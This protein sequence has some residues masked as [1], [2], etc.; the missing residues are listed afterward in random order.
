MSAQEDIAK[1]SS[2]EEVRHRTRPQG[3]S[4]TFGTLKSTPPSNRD[5]GAIPTGLPR[6][7]A[8]LELRSSGLRPSPLGPGRS[9]VFIPGQSTASTRGV[10][11]GEVTEVMGPR[12]VGKTAFAMGIAAS[13]LQAGQKVVWIDTA[14]PVNP[15]RFKDI[16]QKERNTFTPDTDAPSPPQPKDINPDDPLKNLHHFHPPTLA[17]LLALI[18]HPPK[19]FPPPETGLIVIDSI[20]S[21]F[22]SEYRTKMPPKRKSTKPTAES[23]EERTRWKIIGNLAANLKKLATKLNCA[24]ITINEMA[25]RFRPGQPPVLH[26]TLSGV[27]WDAGVATRLVLYWH[28][29]PAEFRARVDVRMKRVRIAEV[30][31][32]ERVG[33]VAG[34]A[35][36]IVPFVI[37]KTG[38]HEFIPPTPNNSDGN[39]TDTPLPPLSIRT[40]NRPN[41]LMQARSK[42][43]LDHAALSSDILE[44]R[45]R[46]RIDPGAIDVDVEIK[47]EPDDQDYVSGVSKTTPFDPS[48]ALGIKGEGEGDGEE[49]CEWLDEDD[50]GGFVGEEVEEDEDGDGDRDGKGENTTPILTPDVV[51]IDEETVLLLENIPDDE[52]FD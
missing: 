16:L 47:A 30:V 5:R 35:G 42:R 27:T 20:S 44:A 43:K 34:R 18:S 25:S 36:R 28:W 45:H 51:D 6:L 7:D 17:H 19:T 11:R 52:E 23:K 14:G 8:A 1:F 26:Q 24:V 15:T 50:P 4:R 21:L 9:Y 31:R 33:L 49:E 38:L 48:M 22:T 41:R 13:V 32:M 29:L 40:P 3:L 37:M 12:G 46:P 10:R 39:G 2:P